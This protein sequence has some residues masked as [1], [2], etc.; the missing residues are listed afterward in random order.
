M[1]LEHRQRECPLLRYTCMSNY[2][3]SHIAGGTFFFTVNLADRSQTLLTSHIDVLERAFSDAKRILPFRIDAIVVLPEHL[4]CI[5]TLP[6]G[7]SDYSARWGVIKANFSR[8]LDSREKTPTSRA[9]RRE[10]TIWQRR[11][12]E[13]GIRDEADRAAHLDYIHYNPVK[14]GYASSAA[15]WPYSSF[16]RFVQAGLYSAG[17]AAADSELPGNRGER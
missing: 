8:R 15:E 7:D 5:W 17:W 6:P 12:W 3:R 14:H 13:H 16:H 11:F 1:L 4:H 10:R 2:R 9:T